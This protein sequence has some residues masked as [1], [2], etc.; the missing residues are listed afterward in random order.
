MKKTPKTFHQKTGKLKNRHALNLLMT[1]THTYSRSAHE[2]RKEKQNAA[3]L[4]NYLY[5]TRIRR[6]VKSISDYCNEHPDAYDDILNAKT[7]EDLNPE[8][9]SRMND[10]VEISREK[11]TLLDDLIKTEWR[12]TQYSRESM[13]DCWNWTRDLR[14][15]LAEMTRC[16]R[17]GKF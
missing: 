4:I 8:L 16:Y 13:N 5:E 7:I 17:S 3:Y 14:I 2:R 15:N 9:R 12:T 6:E 1:Y 10:L 11:H